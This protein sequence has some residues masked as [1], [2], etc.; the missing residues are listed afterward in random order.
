MDRISGIAGTQSTMPS[1]G[2]PKILE[3]VKEET[4]VREA[5]QDFVA[6]T[7]YKQMFQSLRK[8][9]DKPAY[10]HGGSA[11]EMFQSQMDQQVAEDLARDQGNHFS[12]QLF[13]VFAQKFRLRPSNSQEKTETLNP[14]SS[15]PRATEA[16]AGLTNIK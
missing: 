14:P 2:N 9:H 6:G 5:F 15:Q 7:F 13:S 1:V 10:F 16:E 4:S 12:D 8:M 11:E 3:S